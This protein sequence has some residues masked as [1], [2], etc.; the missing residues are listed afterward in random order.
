[1][2]DVDASIRKKKIAALEKAMKSLA[3]ETGDENVIQVLGKK[4]METKEGIPTGILSLDVACGGHGI[5]RGRIVELFGAESS[6][7][8]LIAQKIIAACQ[9]HGGLCAYVD[10]EQTFDVSFAKKLGVQTDDLI[11]SQPNSLQAAFKVIDSLADV[12][13]D[14]IVLDSIAALVPEEEMEGD[15]GKQ[16]V[17]LVARYMSQFLR[18]INV[19]LAN[20]DSILIG[21]NQTRSKIGVMYSNPEVT[22]GGAAMKFYSSLRMRVSSSAEGKIKNGDKVIGKGIKVT[23]VKNKTAP[24]FKTAE[25]NVYFDGRKVSETDQIADIALEHGL[26]PRYNAKGELDPKG[27]QYKWDDEPNFLAKSKAD[28]PVQLD[29]FPNVRQALLE[30]IQRGD[31]DDT[32]SDIEADSDAE[33]TEEEF[34]ARMME[35]IKAIE[36]GKEA[37]EIESSFD[38]M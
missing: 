12:G 10:M 6:G 27:R 17:G 31:L 5:R 36:N 4:P 23:L 19:K 21:I 22:N 2:K 38:E 34:E 32:S 24:P 15:V 14:V 1:M 18:R 13:V 9:V 3:K 25:F 29:K 37:E 33:L 20:S 7:K 30:I 26:I 16:T 8:S 35:D 11:V 28:V